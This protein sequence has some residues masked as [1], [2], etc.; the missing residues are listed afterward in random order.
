[1][2]EGIWLP[3]PQNQFKNT[4]IIYKVSP[5]IK[6]KYFKKLTL[7]FYNGQSFWKASD[8]IHTALVIYN[9]FIKTAKSLKYFL[10]PLLKDIGYLLSVL[11]KK[12][13]QK[14]LEEFPYFEEWTSSCHTWW[15]MYLNIPFIIKPQILQYLK[16]KKNSDNMQ[17]HICHEAIKH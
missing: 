10:L 13:Q 7:C 14:R 5:S 16:K 2:L 17:N 4:K 6:I 11:L 9:V 8:H 15:I 1:M 12:K 3:S